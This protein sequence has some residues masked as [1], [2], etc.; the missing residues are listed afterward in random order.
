[1]KPPVEQGKRRYL[2]EIPIR[3]LL[4][5]IKLDIRRELRTIPISLKPKKMK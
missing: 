3:K 4:A 5:L 1:M 2:S